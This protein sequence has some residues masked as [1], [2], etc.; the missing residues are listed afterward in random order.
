MKRA[1]NSRKDFTII[2]QNIVLFQ[3]AYRVFDYISRYLTPS[4]NIRRSFVII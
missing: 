2:Q 3:R 1:L 4:R